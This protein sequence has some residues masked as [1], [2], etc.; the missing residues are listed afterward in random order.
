MMAKKSYTRENMIVGLTRPSLSPCHASQVT[1][2]SEPTKYKFWIIDD[3]PARL[4]LRVFPSFAHSHRWWI[5]RMVVLYQFTSVFHRYCRS[6]FVVFRM[7]VRS[8]LKT[9]WCDSVRNFPDYL[10][11]CGSIQPSCYLCSRRHWTE[12]STSTVKCRFVQFNFLHPPWVVCG[13]L[14]VNLL[15]V[16]VADGD[17]SYLL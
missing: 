2:S 12:R 3:G 1:E 4:L 9:Y 15:N 8:Q 10:L 6:T 5:S 16:I 17:Q 13:V 7:T 11:Y 14:A